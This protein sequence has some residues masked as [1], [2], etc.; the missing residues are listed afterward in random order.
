MK[1]SR[2]DIRRQIKPDDTVVHIGYFCR[3]LLKR[4]ARLITIDPRPGVV[5][6]GYMMQFGSIEPIAG[7]PTVDLDTIIRE[8]QPNV[9]VRGAW[10]ERL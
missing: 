9:I 2:R 5:G 10:I 4:C 6:G 3:Y 8:H 7:V 1:P